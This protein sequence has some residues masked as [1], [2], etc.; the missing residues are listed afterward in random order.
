MAFEAPMEMAAV[1]SPRDHALL[2]LHGDLGHLV[3]DRVDDDTVVDLVDEPVEA[4]PASCV[5]Y[6]WDLEATHPFVVS[7]VIDPALIPITFGYGRDPVG[8]RD[9]AMFVESAGQRVDR[10]LVP[11]PFA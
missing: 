10:P 6:T 2:Y 1:R 3:T 11:H 5:Y 7:R 9:V 4:P 8:R